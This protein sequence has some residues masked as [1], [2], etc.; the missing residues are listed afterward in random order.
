LYQAPGTGFL[1]ETGS[2]VNFGQWNFFQIQLDYST[3]TYQIFHNT[4]NLGTF[5][6]VDPGL[7][8]FSDADIAAFAAAG[9]VASQAL[10]G[11]AYFDN[12]LVREGICPPIPE[13]ATLGLAAV[14][15]MGAVIRRRTKRTMA[16]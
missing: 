13:P 16:A 2:T 1:T 8:Q 6:F 12:F 15:F 3:D 9:D 5:G 11:T 4:S 14:G 10:A 7:D